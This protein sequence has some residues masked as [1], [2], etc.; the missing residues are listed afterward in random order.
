MTDNNEH[1]LSTA[2][3][4]FAIEAYKAVPTNEK[5]K[6]TGV[7]EGFLIYQYKSKQGL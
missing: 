5:A 2:L 1:I 4:L 7:T 6:T 3:E